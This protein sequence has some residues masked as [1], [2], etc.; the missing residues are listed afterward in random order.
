M[1]YEHS[2]NHQPLPVKYIN[3]FLAHKLTE[4]VAKIADP[5]NSKTIGR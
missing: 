5:N 1:L 2:L 4:V 3:I